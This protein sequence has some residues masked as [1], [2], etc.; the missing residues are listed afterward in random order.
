MKN[1]GKS[2]RK[3]T[4]SIFSVVMMITLL[5][6]GASADCTCTKTPLGDGWPPATQ[7]LT[8][9]CGNRISYT[10]VAA[11][12]TDPTLVQFK[13]LSKGKK[14]YVGWEFGDGIHLSGTKNPVHKYKKTGYYITEMTIRCGNCGKL[15]WVHNN[16]VTK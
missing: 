6:A 8:C 15:M 1:D 10:A 14:S 11:S 16:V 4:L 7:Q 12:E 9:D 2:L 13:D 3:I 5:S